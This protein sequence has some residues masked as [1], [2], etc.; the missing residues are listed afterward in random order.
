MKLAL[1]FVLAGVAGGCSTVKP[2]ERELLAQR[3]MQLTPTPEARAEQ[4]M[5]ESREASAG[6][7]GGGGG[8]CGC[9]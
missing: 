4:H 3:G 2:W 8:G 6:G 1:L 5:L 7:F 9:N